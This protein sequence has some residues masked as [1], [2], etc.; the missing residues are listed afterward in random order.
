MPTDFDQPSNDGNDRLV[1]EHWHET[2]VV[3]RCRGDIDM[4]TAP[5]LGDA[6]EGVLDR[7]PAIVVIDLSEVDFLASAG[8]SML[9]AARDKVSPSAGFAVVA[10]GPGTSR[11]LE[12]VGLSDAINMHPTL[13]AAL[14]SITAPPKD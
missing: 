13:D 6:A 12:I 14:A 10:D 3:L 7:H 5:Q 2:T 4:L 8:M 9:I 1:E 11:P